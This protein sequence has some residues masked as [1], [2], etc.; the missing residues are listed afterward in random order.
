MD[1]RNLVKKI[2][3]AGISAIA[4]FKIMREYVRN[5]LGSTTC[6][7]KKPDYFMPSRVLEEVRIYDH[8]AII[9]REFNIPCIVGTE[10]AAR[11]L[12]DGDMVEVDAYK[13]IVRKIPGL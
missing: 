8:A 2:N 3:D 12:K 5:S 1:K 9:A 13:G 7:F 11:I 6:E 10:N 4:D